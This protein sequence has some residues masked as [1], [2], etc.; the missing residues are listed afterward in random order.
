MSFRPLT[1]YMKRGQ[2]Y[3]MIK[4]KKGRG[5]FQ[6]LSYEIEHRCPVLI[7]VTRYCSYYYD[8]IYCDI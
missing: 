3:L 8:I 6:L 5:L 1:P 2:N 4:T 7:N